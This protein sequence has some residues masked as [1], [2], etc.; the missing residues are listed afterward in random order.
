MNTDHLSPTQGAKE[1]KCLAQGLTVAENR[2]SKECDKYQKCTARLGKAEAK[3]EIA[4]IE[5]GAAK[6]TL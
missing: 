5:A 2:L 3:L 1:A 4:K 6:M